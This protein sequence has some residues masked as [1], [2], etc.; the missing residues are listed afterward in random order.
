MLGRY[1]L[2]FKPQTRAFVARWMLE[3]VQADYEL[4]AIDLE[5]G[6][7][8]APA[9]LAINPMGKVPT[10]I[11][12]DGTVMTESAAILAHLADCF[13]EASL[14]PE[15]GTSARAIYYRWLFFAPSCLEPA[16]VD[17]MMRKDSE[18]LPKHAVGWGS[19]DDVV[20]TVEGQLDRAAYVTGETFTAADLAVGAALWWMTQFGAPRMAQSQAIQSFIGRVTA[21]DAFKRAQAA[22]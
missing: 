10:L 11:L 14:A 3:E 8:R 9:F 22:V 20:D 17:V 15:I 4:A 13:P 7:N 21:R 6:E 19:Y 16:T 12:P 1:K 18:P 2:Y 5:A